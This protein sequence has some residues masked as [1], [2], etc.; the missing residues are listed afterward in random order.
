MMENKKL[1][2]ITL[3]VIIIGGIVLISFY[4]SKPK[5][6]IPSA[7]NAGTT[8]DVTISTDKNDYDKGEII[9]IIVKNGLDKPILYF[10]GGDRFWGIEYFK[11]DKWIN[12]AYESD[13]GF[14]LTEENLE[15]NCYVTL[16][17][18]MPPSELKSQ[19][20]ISSQWNQKICPF[21][22]GSPAEPRTV[23]Y[24][25]NGQY[26][27]VL[28]YGFEISDDDPYRLLEIKTIYSNTFTIK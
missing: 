9:N 26:R 13:G 16:Y 18:R 12:P 11:D 24:I 28:N 4:I 23:R 22:T 20:S 21:G 10:S 5:Q 14:Q 17:E 25:D 2:I 19:S 7:P 15:D 6:I 1:I 8:P 3:L 27:L